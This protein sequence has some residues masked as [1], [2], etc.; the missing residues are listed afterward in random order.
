[1]SVRRF[2]FA[3]SAKKIDYP[4]GTWFLLAPQLQPA[5]V[6][7]SLRKIVFFPFIFILIIFQSSCMKFHLT[8][9][10]PFTN[11]S[12]LGYSLFRWFVYWRARRKITRITCLIYT[13]RIFL[14]YYCYSVLRFCVFFFVFLFFLFFCLSFDHFRLVIFVWFDEGVRVCAWNA[15]TIW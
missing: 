8:N 14:L 15:E 12:R 7:A 11:C 10:T 2:W 6:F 13:D 5:T 4:L 1:M 3:K 9:I